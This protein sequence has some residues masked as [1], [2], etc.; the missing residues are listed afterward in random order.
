VQRR[1]F[2]TRPGGAAGADRSELPYPASDR[3][4]AQKSLLAIR[5]DRLMMVPISTLVRSCR[6]RR[7]RSMRDKQKPAADAHQRSKSTKEWAS[8]AG[9]PCMKEVAGDKIKALP[10]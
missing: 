8:I 4:V 7:H 2:T 6:P 3:G 5:C 10:V 9:L 1:D